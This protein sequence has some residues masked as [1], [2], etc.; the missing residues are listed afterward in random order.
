MEFREFTKRDKGAV[1]S[2]LSVC[3]Y[4]YLGDPELP[5]EGNRR[6]LLDQMH[7]WLSQHP[8][9]SFVISEQD[10]VLGVII[11][12]KSPWDS[13]H[14]GFSVGN[15][16]HLIS[17]EK[18]ETKAFET[19][20]C[21]LEAGTSWA[22][23]HKIRFLLSRSDGDD[24]TNIHALEDHGFHFVEDILYFKYDL[25]S[26]T[27]LRH[28]ELKVRLSQERDLDS[29]RMIAGNTFVHS[30]FHRDPHIEKAKAD[31]LY[32]K[33]IETSLRKEPDS[34]LVAEGEG[35]VLGFIIC[36]AKDLADYFGKRIMVVRLIGVSQDQ[37]GKGVGYHLFLGALNFFKGQTD[38]V[39][40]SSASVN[41][42]SSRLL[43]KL[44][45]KLFS[46][47][48]TF[49]K[50]FRMEGDGKHATAEF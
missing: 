22:K 33:W 42:S 14:F 26:P 30:R 49:H 45:F 31:R 6:F 12:G 50:W 34:I 43:L 47:S 36:E 7:L 24:L 35:K 4:R 46:S 1:D 5:E 29:L 8:E 16:L 32:E 11:C 28:P 20:K 44:G 3:S 21:L 41:I 38:I 18:E 48:L 40:G 10:S 2:I 27:D 9:S 39:Y 25:T 15:I 37:K 23:R 13:E 19:K 17:S